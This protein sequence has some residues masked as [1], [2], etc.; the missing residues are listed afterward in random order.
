M[1]DDLD[2]IYNEYSLRGKVIDFLLKKQYPEE[3]F[4]IDWEKDGQVFSLA[5]FDPLTRKLLAVFEPL[6]HN[7]IV[8]STEGIRRVVEKY[9][10]LS[11][12][13]KVP[14]YVISGTKGKYSLLVSKILYQT[15]KSNLPHFIKVPELP[16]FEE[17]KQKVL[18]NTMNDNFEK[19]TDEELEGIIRKHENPDV[20]GSRFQ[21]AMTELDLRYKKRDFRPGLHLEV[22][23]DMNMDGGS[24]NLGEGQQMTAKVRGSFSGKKTKVFIGNQDQNIEQD[25]PLWLKY[26]GTI[27][28]ILALIWGVFIY[29]KP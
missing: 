17:L 12:D 7:P 24:V 2:P 14:L 5:V 22:G 3:S 8:I 4:N 26:V 23:G 21:R 25:I 6:V 27:A 10:N 16:N 20:S 15:K 19:M 18:G 28:T 13:P 11:S 29:F 1:L 9:L